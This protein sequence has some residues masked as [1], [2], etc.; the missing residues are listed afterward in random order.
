MPYGCGE[1]APFS[2]YVIEHTIIAGFFQL[3]RDTCELVN[4]QH[5]SI[6]G[7]G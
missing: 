6:Y 3:I 2:L 1:T 4:W 7:G 5:T